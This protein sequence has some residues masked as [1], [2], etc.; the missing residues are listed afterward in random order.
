MNVFLVATTEDIA[1]QIPKAGQYRCLNT[2]TIH[3]LIHAVSN[4]GMMYRRRNTTG[5]HALG[6]V[7][8]IR[9]MQI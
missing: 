8:S 4:E 2:N 3:K 5:K 1:C 7:F 6:I 9:K